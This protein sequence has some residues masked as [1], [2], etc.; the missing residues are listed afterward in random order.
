MF[1]IMVM[2]FGEAPLSGFVGLEFPDSKILSSLCGSVSDFFEGLLFKAEAASTDETYRIVLS[3]SSSPSDLDAHFTGTLSNGSSFHCY[4][5]NQN[6][7]DNSKLVA[8]LDTD[9]TSSYGPETITVSTSVKNGTYYVYNFSGL[10]TMTNSAAKVSLY[11][12]NTFIGTYN[13]PVS[14]N[15]GLYWTLFKIK[16]GKVYLVNT[17]GSSVSG[18]SGTVVPGTGNNS[19]TS[20]SNNKYYFKIFSNENEQEFVNKTFTINGVNYTTDDTGIVELS[21]LPSGDTIT[22]SHNGFHDY[23][24]NKEVLTYKNNGLG[25]VKQIYLN[26]EVSSGRPVISSIHIRNDSN[27]SAWIDPVASKYKIL[28]D[29]KDLFDIKIV[30][31]WNSQTPGRI[32]LGQDSKRSIEI[33]STGIKSSVLINESLV[34]GKELYVYCLS[35]GGASS[36]GNSSSEVLKTKIEIVQGGNSV[37]ETAN[38]T[39]R[40]PI[41]DA[42]SLNIPNSVPILGGNEQ[43]L[44][45]DLG[46]YTARVS[47][48]GNKYKIAVGV[49]DSAGKGEKLFE[50]ANWTDF[51]SM[52]NDSCE[53][54][55]N[56][57]Y[58]ASDDV[59][60]F[61]KDIK[62]KKLLSTFKVSFETLAFAEYEAVDGGLVFIDGGGYVKIGGS[63]SKPYYFPCGFPVYLDFSFG[64]NVKGELGFNREFADSTIP[65]RFYFDI[66]AEIVSVGVG[67]ALGL[68]GILNAGVYGGGAVYLDWKVR[69]SY[70]DSGLK[71]NISLKIQ[72]LMFK[73]SFTVLEGK[74]SFTDSL[75]TNSI[76]STTLVNGEELYDSSTYNEIV[77]RDYLHKTQWLGGAHP[78]PLSKGEIP[79]Y[80]DSSTGKI[81]DDYLLTNSISGESVSE[82]SILQSNIYADS[83]PQLVECNNKKLLVWISD[84]QNRT[85]ENMT[86]LSFSVY[87]SET[88]SWSAPQA[89][90]DDGTAD[91]YPN[92]KTDGNDIYVVWQNIKS[93]MT[94]DDSELN[95]YAQ[96][97]EVCFAKFNFGT[98]QFEQQVNLTD[99]SNADITPCIATKNGQLAVVWIT[100]SAS[101]MFG[102]EGTNSI[103]YKAYQNGIWSEKFTAV[104]DLTAVHSYDADYVNGNLS[105]AYASDLDNNFDS[106]DDVELYQV[107]VKADG[108]I[109]NYQITNN[110]TIDCKPQYATVNGKQGLYWSNLSEIK[111]I[112]DFDSLTVKSVFADGIMANDTFVVTDSNVND[113]YIVWLE[114][115]DGSVALVASR[116]VGNEWSVPIVVGS[117]EEN[118]AN[119]SAVYD[120]EGKMFVAVN[121]TAITETVNGSGE[122]LFDE[123]QTDLCVLKVYDNADITVEQNALTS[124]VEEILPGNTIYFNTVFSNNGNL[125]ID[126]VDI[127]VSGNDDSTITKEVNLKPGE[128]VAVDIPYVLPNTI[129]KHIVSITINPSEY[130]DVDIS[131]NSCSFNLGLPELAIIDAECLKYGADVLINTTIKN[132]S[133]VDSGSFK[134][135]IKE[136]NSEGAVI[137]EITPENISSNEASFFSFRIDERYIHYNENGLKQ[138]YIE[139]VSDE[140][141]YLIGNNSTVVSVFSDTDNTIDYE[142]LETDIEENVCFVYGAIYNNSFESKSVYAKTEVFDENNKLIGV[143]LNQID[144]KE[145]GVVTI[146]NEISIIERCTNYTTKTT[147]YDVESNDLEFE[148]PDGIETI[149]SNLISGEFYF[150]SILIPDSIKTIEGDVFSSCTIETFYYEGTCGEWCSIDIENLDTNPLK[151]SCEI[152]F[153]NE[154]FDGTVQIPEG[155]NTFNFS[156]LNNLGDTNITELYLPSSLSSIEFENLDDFSNLEAIHVEEENSIYSSLDGIL[157]NKEQSELIVVPSKIYMENFFIPDSV[158]TISEHAFEN[159]CNLE[160][161]YFHENVVNVPMDIENDVW[162]YGL[163]SSQVIISAESVIKDLLLDYF[164]TVGVYCTLY[165]SG[166]CGEN[167][168]WSFAEGDLVIS[169][170]GAIDDYLTATPSLIDAIAQNFEMPEQIPWG[171]FVDEITSV[172]VEEGITRIGSGAFYGIYAESGISLPETLTEIGAFAFGETYCESLSIPDSVT[173]IEDFAFYLSPIVMIS[174]GSDVTLSDN[175]MFMSMIGYVDISSENPFL[176]SVN[177]TY[178]YSKDGTKLIYRSPFSEEE[179]IVI[180]DSVTEIGNAAMVFAMSENPIIIPSNV[181]V[182][183]DAAFFSA[184]APEIVLSEGLKTIGD[185][186]FIG[187][188]ISELNIPASVEKMGALLTECFIIV[189]EDNENYCSIESVVLSKDMESLV[190]YPIFYPSDIQEIPEGINIKKLEPYSCM[191]FTDIVYVPKTVEEIAENAFWGSEFEII[192]APDSVTYVSENAFNN[193]NDFKAA[194]SRN[195]YFYEFASE[196]GIAVIE[197]GYQVV[198]YPEKREY[199]LGEELSVGGMKIVFYD[200]TTFNDVTD[201]FVASGYNRSKA[202][203]QTITLSFDGTEFSYDIYVSEYVYSS[204]HPYDDDVWEYEYSWE[205][206]VSDNIDY[207]EIEFSDKSSIADGDEIIIESLQEVYDEEYDGYYYEPISEMVVE[208]FDEQRTFAIP[209]D[210]DCISVRLRTNGDG[211]NDYGFDI[212]GAKGKMYSLDVYPLTYGRV[213]VGDTVTLEAKLL[214]NIISTESVGWHSSNNHLAVVDQTGNVTFKGFGK[215]TI[216]ATD[217]DGRTGSYTFNVKSSNPSIE[218]YNYGRS[219]SVKVDWWKPYSSATMNLGFKAFNCEG[220]AYY[221]WKSDNRRVKVDKGLITNTGYFSRSAKITVTAYDFEGNVVTKSSIRVSFY[222][223]NWQKDKLK[224]QAVVSDDFNL[225]D[226]SVDELESQENAMLYDIF[227]KIFNFMKNI[228]KNIVSLF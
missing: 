81:K 8:S 224:T 55:D 179:T 84:N 190:Y 4:Y 109:S 184:E 149:S 182:I 223:F 60:G 114:Q 28:K 89:V 100:N 113:A 19:Q 45:I 33:P 10:G 121:R 194:C 135:V 183:G 74:Y 193:T 145:K 132:N 39:D 23:T 221:T 137:N 13:V 163:W 134:L 20:L 106:S 97:S 174:I 30:V 27:D 104:D 18:N 204:D 209:A 167:A 48:E 40:L 103:N 3:W 1:M 208:S 29:S 165:A 71:G 169:G 195:S 142:L 207:V 66:E 112:T 181:K 76:S 59:W 180:P 34:V 127:T 211:K 116:F 101:D 46:A 99:D 119:P 133:C 75:Q 58:D 215:V 63:I 218:I 70:V 129:E 227:Y 205:Y 225:K 122:T 98:S 154:M 120:H 24:F 51:K 136:D 78:I 54:L 146:Q 148:I 175:A 124:T 200:G 68:S 53:K 171:E 141:E 32:V 144:V 138:Y 14:S 217:S 7:Y 52:V 222:K 12:G 151:F 42:L 25:K 15:T 115:Y 49:Q 50:D 35:N 173:V 44:G 159:A 185:F 123:G 197:I 178:I 80:Y 172:V 216:T 31:D 160:K 187:A 228:F 65:L 213:E 203:T 196:N 199:V 130:D 186:S 6:V 47:R 210:C 117:V 157:Y 62:D 61:K 105:I 94:E 107:T 212:V 9:D 43:S 153:N 206:I 88:E 156:S 36:K 73:K 21:S 67:V 90:C 226:L 166:T 83:K 108:N 176:T 147:I 92:V 69:D 91:F 82:L 95:I 118:L 37:F 87:D 57:D 168:T 38:E 85:A 5:S 161:V 214:N 170:S 77:D 152:Y 220:V 198:H 140:D 110:D 17:I 56:V 22:I 111:C 86:M 41:F 72:A 192:V 128:S 79:E 102:L 189:D 131:D 16:D 162:Y 202:G 96:N 139:I 93:V 2:V 143:A 177:G 125:E 188:S 11:K 126:T 219:N 164:N 191:L 64:A 26:A 150:N 155:T 201:N 158:T